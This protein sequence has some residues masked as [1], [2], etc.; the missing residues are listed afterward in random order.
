MEAAKQQAPAVP[1]ASEAT[2]GAKRKEKKDGEKKKSTAQR[3]QEV[4][5]QRHRWLPSV[6][7][8][9]WAQHNRPCLAGDVIPADVWQAQGAPQ[10]PQDPQ[11]PLAYYS[12]A[13]QVLQLQQS[14]GGAQYT[15]SVVPS[16]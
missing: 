15:L 13:R 1:T 16:P 7:P 14:R 10:R 3:T 6:S 5:L 8:G 9:S 12:E 2:A 4:S 11:R